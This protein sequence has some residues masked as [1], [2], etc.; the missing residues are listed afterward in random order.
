MEFVC[1]WPRNAQHQHFVEINGE[2]M[3]EPTRIRDKQVSNRRT[4]ERK[5]M[6]LPSQIPNMKFLFMWSAR[7][8][9]RLCHC[10]FLF[11]YRLLLFL[12]GTSRGICILHFYLNVPSLRCNV[13]M[14]TKRTVSIHIQNEKILLALAPRLSFSFT[15]IFTHKHNHIYC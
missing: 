9:K 6:I 13:Y 4:R 10:W 11:I 14:D 12:C 5:H 1:V 8:R 3:N 15:F 7:V 2:R